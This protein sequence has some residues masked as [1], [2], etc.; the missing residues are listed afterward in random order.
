MIFRQV[1]NE[2]LKDVII[3]LEAGKD[4]DKS[5]RELR[6]YLDP[7]QVIRVG[8]RLK[9]ADRLPLSVRCPVLL[10][11]KHEYSRRLVEYTHCKLLDHCGGKNTLIAE[12]R[13]KVWIIGIGQLAKLVIKNCARCSRSVKTRPLNIGIAPLHFSRLPLAG[14]CAFHEI[15]IDM[16]GPF[17]SKHGRTRAVCKRFVLLFACCWT[18]ALS[19]EVMDG[20]ST[21][22]CVSAFLRHC[23][24][25][26]FPRY[27]NSDRGSNLV[28]LDRHLQDRWKV[29][30]TEFDKHKQ[31][32]PMIR[33]HFNPPYSPRFS[34]HI[35][36]MVKIMKTSL[37]KMLG[38]PQ[39]LFRDEQLNTLIK[40]AQGYAN[41][42]P[43]TT[44]SNSPHDEPPLTPADFLLT[45]SRFLGGIPE[46]EDG[47][48]DWRTRKESLGKATRELWEILNKEYLTAL[49]KMPFSRGEKELKVGM[50]VLLLDKQLPSGKYCMGKV[51]SIRKGPDGKGRVFEIERGGKLFERSAMTLAPLEALN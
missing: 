43:L 22:S 27:V 4:V 13:W 5:F 19:L 29:L 41:R 8:G 44:P 18:R 48:Y 40:L 31:D 2:C 12:V 36:T 10:D 20:A 42:R 34:G 23:S 6:P 17:F 30:E 32:W 28:G 16:A 35:E 50:I 38:Q 7:Q 33:W 26:G 45:G 11:G 25:F 49:Q 46:M 3:C 39:H 24:T 47:N 15:G 21:E 51:K 9:H 37:R 1:Q 14:G